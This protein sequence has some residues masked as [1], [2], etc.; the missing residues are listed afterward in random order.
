VAF[1]LAV[2]RREAPRTMTVTGVVFA[3]L[4]VLNSLV[5]PPMPAGVLLVN[6]TTGLLLIAG[7]LV[8]RDPRLP[9]ALA[10]WILAIGALALVVIGLVEV[11]ISPD[12]VAFTYVV[13]IIVIYPMLTLAWLPAGVVAVPMLV[14]C[15]IVAS[16]RFGATAADWFVASIAA[17]SLGLALLWLRSRTVD[18][19]ADKSALVGQL[20]TRDRLTGTLNRH[21]VAD[22]LPDLLALAAR[23][24][25]QVFAVFAD[26][27]GLKAVNDTHG[28]AVGD[29]VLVATADA[30][31]ATVRATDLVGRWGGDEFIVLGMG[32]IEQADALSDRIRGNALAGGVDPGKWAGGI[33]VGVAISDLAEIDIEALIRQADADMYTRRRARRAGSKG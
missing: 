10:P 18:E 16:E 21:G 9:A 33:S 6:V 24:G 8:I 13:V 26:V 14:G 3:L 23:H 30:I 20:A 19:L 4:T 22:R 5:G 32:H 2:V 7:G 31:R 17:V 29:A 15:V 12:A 28:H 27:D 25:E 11:W 1:R